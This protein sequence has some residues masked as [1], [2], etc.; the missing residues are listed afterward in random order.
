M[1]EVICHLDDLDSAWA[2]LRA[3]AE[4]KDEEDGKNKLVEA[5]NVV[6]VNLVINIQANPLDTLRKHVKH[7][8]I[9]F[10]FA[11]CTVWSLFIVFS[12]FFLLTFC[13][14]LTMQTVPARV[15]FAGLWSASSKAPRFST[16][17]SST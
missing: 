16:Q 11:F 14:Q 12:C 4:A 17:R 1:R 6:E 2:S 15:H 13:F 3:V 9:W 5:G 8:V 7:K 10:F